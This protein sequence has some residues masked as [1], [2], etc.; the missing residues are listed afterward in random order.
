MIRSCCARK[1]RISSKMPGSAVAWPADLEVGS[2]GVAPIR[3]RLALPLA[4]S[5]PGLV[6]ELGE[7][8]GWPDADAPSTCRKC[9]MTVA[10]GWISGW[11][12]TDT[13]PP[14]GHVH[15]LATRMEQV[16][17]QRHVKNL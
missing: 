17:I 4:R 5:Q 11:P 1:S 3:L 14:A 13:V 15:D 7:A 9:S 8:A 10:L 2:I 16:Q 12:W 6:A